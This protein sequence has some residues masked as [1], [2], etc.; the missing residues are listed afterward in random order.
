[1]NFR[2][3]TH[4]GWQSDWLLRNAS[5]CTIFATLLGIII[6]YVSAIDDVQNVRHDRGFEGNH[7]LKHLKSAMAT[8]SR[9][10][11]WPHEKLGYTLY[12]PSQN[13]SDR[14][15]SEVNLDLLY[16][17]ACGSMWE[18][19]QSFNINKM[20]QGLTVNSCLRCQKLDS[21]GSGIVQSC[22]FLVEASSSSE[23]SYEL[24]TY[25]DT[26]CADNESSV[27]VSTWDTG[28]CYGDSWQYSF[29]PGITDLSQLGNGLMYVYYQDPEESPCTSPI[30]ETSLVG[31]YEDYC[32]CVT[33]DDDYNG[34]DDDP[35][36]CATLHYN[37]HSSVTVTT[38]NDYNSCKGSNVK[39]TYTSLCMTDDAYNGA[40]HIGDTFTN[41]DVAA[42]INA[43]SHTVTA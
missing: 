21:K 30:F 41:D 27:S 42:Y 24:L 31:Y 33:D 22:K 10:V 7:I 36:G 2:L 17:S 34:D 32:Y 43:S 15:L 3:K 1:M 26:D 6:L 4:R 16:A 29:L 14:A 13:F 9:K 18:K 38:Y 20:T 12:P 8:G 11:Q 37:G 40:W 23:L 28:T 35:N 25:T 19:A 5:S 39:N